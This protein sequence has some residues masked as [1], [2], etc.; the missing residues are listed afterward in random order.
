MSAEP[1]FAAEVRAYLADCAAHPGLDPRYHPTAD[2]AVKVTWH[3]GQD[4]ADQIRHTFA[5]L[6]TSPAT[7]VA[8]ALQPPGPPRPGPTLI[9]TAGD[10]PN[11]RT[12]A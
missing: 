12:T 6:T 9:D 1:P 10:N 3:R 8:P 4:E 11:A 2:G 5:A 7:G